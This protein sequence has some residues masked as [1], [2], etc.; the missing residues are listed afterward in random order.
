MKTIK[1]LLVITIISGIA[2]FILDGLLFYYGRNDFN[3]YRLLP[4]DIIPDDKPDFENGFALKDKNGFTI[5][6]KGNIYRFK[7]KEV[8]INLVQSYCY[9][10]EKV[11]AKIIDKNN[12]DYYVEFV[13]NTDKQTNQDIIARI[14]DNGSTFG[15]G[16]YNCV[17]IKGNE[18]KIKRM[19]YP[20][21]Y[22]MIIFIVLFIVTIYKALM[23]FRERH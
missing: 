13:G 16:E 21:N 7:D 2:Y 6:A 4:L 5:A 14:G 9:N 15:T 10:A 18:I 22:L 11:V 1:I 19:E 17:I 12:E 8:H 23:L 3:F 20:R